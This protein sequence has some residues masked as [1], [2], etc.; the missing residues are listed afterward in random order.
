MIWAIRKQINLLNNS[1]KYKLM[2]LTASRKYILAFIFIFLFAEIQGQNEIS[3]NIRTNQIWL[4]FNPSYN[5]NE[6]FT[7]YGDVIARTIL[8]SEWSRFAL[9][10]SIKYTFPKPIFSGIGVNQVN[11]IHTGI[12]F[13]K[14]FN[15]VY[16][17]F[18]NWFLRGESFI[19]I[20]HIQK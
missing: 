13:F 19:S 2:G 6:Y 5:L 15:K 7:V 1:L 16:S 12:R 18:Y 11:E 4:D 17:Y 14:T 9:G 10:P 20:K 3:K 8:T